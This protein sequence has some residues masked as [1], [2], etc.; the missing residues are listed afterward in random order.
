MQMLQTSLS[1][2]EAT[3]DGGFVGDKTTC[4]SPKQAQSIVKGSEWVCWRPSTSWLGDY[5]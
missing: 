5:L 1:K 3:V 4:L 2:I